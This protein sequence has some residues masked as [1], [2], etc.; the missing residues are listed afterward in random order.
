MAMVGFSFTK[1]SAEKKPATGQAVNIES[2][3]GVVNIVELP[4]IDPKKVL[5]RFDFNFIV[6]YGPDAGKIELNG[7]VIELY[8]KEFGTKVV[9]FWNKEKKLHPE[10]MQE[11]F[12]TVLARS[13]TEAIIIGRDMG[14]PSPIQMPRVD[15]KPKDKVAEKPKAEAK[16]TKEPKAEKS[17]K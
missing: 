12:N 7:E 14:L 8:D 16:E 13:N 1:I 5:I 11:V 4:V 6:K 2:N 10:V 15:V 3:A 17:K 9:D